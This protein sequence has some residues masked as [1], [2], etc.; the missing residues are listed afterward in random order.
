MSKQLSYGLVLYTRASGGLQVLLV[1]PGGPYWSGKDEGA[2]SVPKGLGE[3][4][5]EPLAA[6]QREFLELCSIELMPMADTP[7]AHWSAL[8]FSGFWPTSRLAAS[9]S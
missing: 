8:L 9:I 6:A 7:V 2:W 1:H 4:G 3:P 5:E